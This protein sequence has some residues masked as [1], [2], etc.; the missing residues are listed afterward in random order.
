MFDDVTRDTA[1]IRLPR[2]GQVV[3][4]EGAVPWLVV[5]PAGIPVEPGPLR[6]PGCL[7]VAQN[8]NSQ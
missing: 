8:P 5:D 3:P 1:S 2:W 6:G 7:T 4:A